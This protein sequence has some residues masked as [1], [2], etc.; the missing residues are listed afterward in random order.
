MIFGSFVALLALPIH[1]AGLSGQICTPIDLVKYPNLVALG[2]N[3]V[4]PI[5]DNYVNSFGAELVSE[6]GK[7]PQEIPIFIIFD[8]LSTWLYGHTFRKLILNELKVSDL[9]VEIDDV[10]VISPQSLFGGLKVN[11]LA[12][13][14]DVSV[15]VEKCYRFRPS[16][17]S[18]KQGNY[19]VKSSMTKAHGEGVVTMALASCPNVFSACTLRSLFKNVK[20]L[21]DRSLPEI[22]SHIFAGG[23]KVESLKI[24]IP[25]DLDWN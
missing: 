16:R 8:T 5:L 18:I 22:A 19:K 14:L 15:I 20:A 13:E 17:C 24:T 9:T 12:F 7:T 11:R 6:W 25:E 10:Q 21:W 3:K 23:Y 4:I 1:G 2:N